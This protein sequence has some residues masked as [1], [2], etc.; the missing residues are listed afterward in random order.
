MLCCM[1]TAL[2]FISLSNYLVPI[3]IQFFADFSAT[4]QVYCAVLFKPSN[5]LWL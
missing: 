3:L 4:L 2:G 1:V 5:P